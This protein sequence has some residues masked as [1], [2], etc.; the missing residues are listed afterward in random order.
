MLQSLYVIVFLLSFVGVV[1]LGWCYLKFE[2]LDLRKESKSVL[3]EQAQLA[4]ELAQFQLVLANGDRQSQK[5]ARD[6]FEKTF[7]VLISKTSISALDPYAGIGP[8]T[9]A[10]LKANGHQYLHSL[11]TAKLDAIE[12]IGSKR[13]SDIR[14]A[15]TGL[16]QELRS[17]LE[18]GR[19]PESGE[20]K[21]KL[22]SL[23]G[24]T[25]K[26]KSL[27]QKKTD[28]AKARF[29]SLEPAVT[30]ALTVTFIRWL[31]NQPMADSIPVEK[32]LPDPE[33]ETDFVLEKIESTGEKIPPKPQNPREALELL[34]T[35]VLT[36]TL[37]RTQWKMLLDKYDT[38]RFAQY[39]LEFV[40][41]AKAKQDLVNQGA[42]HLL[43]ELGVDP[44][45]EPAVR[46]LR[47]NADLDAAFG[48]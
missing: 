7:L 24:E 23:H 10:R 42:K 5:K 38:D 1:V 44:M 13:A 21:L 30:A 4:A 25:E 12:G 27:S 46:D 26:Q 15:M 16:Y 32:S 41:L 28:Q 20:L 9:L 2:A 45:A 6:I 47:E 18:S 8:V 31:F 48:L 34:S 37:V 43:R 40:D 35:V 3:R 14:L 11:T 22:K 39:G 36:E 29:Q 17:R 19:C 33:N